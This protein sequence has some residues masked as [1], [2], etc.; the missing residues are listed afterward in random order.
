MVLSS[1][2]KKPTSFLRSMGKE[3]RR[4]QTTTQHGAW[5]CILLICMYPFVT[6]L[7]PLNIHLYASRKQR[8]LKLGK[9]GDTVSAKLGSP[10][11]ELECSIPALLRAP[12]LHHLLWSSFKYT[13]W[14]WNPY[15]QKCCQLSACSIGLTSRK[16]TYAVMSMNNWQESK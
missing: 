9:Q 13:D 15:M 6:L 11:W 8:K 5:F 12:I 2:T 7:V 3:D 10:K 14:K 16:I 4:F 1:M